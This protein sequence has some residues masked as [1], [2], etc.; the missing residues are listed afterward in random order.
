M[1]PSEA[2]ESALSAS[3]LLDRSSLSAAREETGE[4]RGRLEL[5]ERAESSLREKR[6]R[7]QA[8]L[9]AERAKRRRLSEQL[10]AEQRPWWRKMFGG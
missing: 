9:E 7:L 6:D 10:E 3:E 2:R 1:L 8:E 4:L 5:T